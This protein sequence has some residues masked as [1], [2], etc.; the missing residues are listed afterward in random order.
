MAEIQ[1]SQCAFRAKYDNNPK[2]FLGR[3]WRWHANWCP[4]W[5]EYMKS[6][7]EQ[8]RNELAKR[9]QLKKYLA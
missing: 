7:S 9:Y 8:E 2:S 3:L 1:C 6:L 5:K 4:G